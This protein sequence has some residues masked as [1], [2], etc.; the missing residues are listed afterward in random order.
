MSKDALIET[1]QRH[2]PSAGQSFLMSFNE[3]ALERYLDHL[4]IL[5]R[6]RGERGASWVRTAETP[7]V[8][9]RTRGE[10]A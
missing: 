6:P 8:V 1:I 2:N 10:A 3:A 9:A 5:A 4:Q 7:A